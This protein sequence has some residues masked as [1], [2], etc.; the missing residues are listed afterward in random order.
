M[1]ESKQIM[2]KCKKCGTAT[3]HTPAQEKGPRL[4]MHCAKCLVT[5]ASLGF[6]FPHAWDGDVMKADCVTCH[7]RVSVPYQ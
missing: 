2:Y 3:G 5:V 4:L 6:I 7:T 1:S